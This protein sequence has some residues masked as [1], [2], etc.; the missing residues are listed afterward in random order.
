MTGSSSTYARAAMMAIRKITAPSK[1]CNSRPV[2]PTRCI[3][4]APISTVRV[5]APNSHQ[6]I[7]KPIAARCS[8]MLSAQGAGSSGFRPSLNST[9]LNSEKITRRTTSF[10]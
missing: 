5:R 6:P 1:S 7:C 10:Q 2:C 9:T 8:G 4:T 3:I